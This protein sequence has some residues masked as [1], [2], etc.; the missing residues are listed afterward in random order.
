MILRENKILGLIEETAGCTCW[1]IDFGRSCR[2]LPRRVKVGMKVNV[3]RN[4]F[5]MKEHFHQHKLYIV[6]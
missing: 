5:Q 2:L 6:G 3:F 4:K 1:R